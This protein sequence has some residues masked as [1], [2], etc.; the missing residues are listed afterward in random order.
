[1]IFE[2]KGET[3]REVAVLTAAITAQVEPKPALS[4]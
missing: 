2:E 1:M 3:R 4:V